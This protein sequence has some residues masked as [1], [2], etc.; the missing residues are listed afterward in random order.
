MRYVLALDQGT[1]S[2]R[3]IVFNEQGAPVA[4]AARE[5]PQY[6]P[7]P[8]WVEHDAE[9]I[10]AS[11]LAV[12]REALQ[13][14]NLGA[15]DVAAIGV[16]NQRETSVVW[17]RATGQPL[18]RA[19]V[20]QCRRTAER[21]AELRAAGLSDEVR[22]RTGL[23]LDPYFSATKLE[24]FLTH[25]PGLRARAERGEVA[26]GTIDSFLLWRL[27][28]GRLHLTDV[29]NAAR[30]MLLNIG[31]L[32]WDDELLRL[33]DVPSA[34]LPQVRSSS[35]V[36][37]TTDPALFGAAIPLAGIAGDQQAATFGQACYQPGMA[38]NTYG[39]GCFLLMNTG[40]QP[41]PSRAADHRGLAGGRP[42]HLRS[43]G[44]RVYRWG[45]GAVAARR[46]G[47]HR[48]RSGERSAGRQRGRQQRRLCGAG[49]CGPG[50][51]LLG[52]G[53]AGHHHRPDPGCHPRPHRPGHP[54][55]AVLPDA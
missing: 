55:G 7:Q 48:Q 37:G 8:G 45:G 1:T 42:G 31:S 12:A 39:T 4:G 10:W 11:Q 36:Y 33:F 22:R 19:I 29:S 15:G 27:S 38:K 52:P 26:F 20:W 23:V 40:T 34:M 47:Y 30:T 25:V 35:E 43:G 16:T 5:Y 3:A 21:C 18:A 54:G 44:Q 53:G 6:Y 49:L 41:R 13:R 24:W 28:G 9:E 14:A 51:A 50:R 2:S 17:D 32:Q 46:P